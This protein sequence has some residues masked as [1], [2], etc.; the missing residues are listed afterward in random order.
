MNLKAVQILLTLMVF[1][2]FGPALRDANASH[3]SNPAWAGHAKFHMVW[4]IAMMVAL[5][6][7]N[8]YLIWGRKPVQFR[9]LALSA[10]F[11]GCTLIGFWTA[12]VLVDVYG[13]LIFVPGI[14]LRVFGLDENVFTFILLTAT[15]IVAV[16]MLVRRRRSMEPAP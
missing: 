7:V 6:G 3:A 16:A 12:C 8:L 13:G 4:F 1:E 2:Y 10:A 9:D 15:W 11:Q 5:G 14:H